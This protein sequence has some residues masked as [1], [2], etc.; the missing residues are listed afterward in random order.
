MKA[1]RY[2]G[3][4]D[5]RVE[6]V[7][8]PKIE[9]PTDVILKV[10]ST[11]ICGSD[12][13]MYEGRTDVEEGKIFGHEVM[14]IIDQAGD[15]VQLLHKGDRVVLPFN[16]ACGTCFN[17]CRGFTNACLF[18]SEEGSAG[19][20]YG[21]AGMGPYRGGQAEYVR[22]PFADFNALKLPGVPHDENEDNFLMLADIL[23]T[24]F[25]AATL[26]KVATGHSVAIYGGGPVGLLSVMSARLM[27][28]ADIYLVDPVPSRL[29]KA[30]ELGA[31]PVNPADGDPVKQIRKARRSIALKDAAR[32]GEELLLHGVLS[33]IDA[34][35][36]QAHNLQNIDEERHQQ[37]I[38]QLVNLTLPTGALG[39]I[40]VY[41]PQDPGGNDENARE[42]VYPLP[43]GQLW[44]KGLSLGTG[45]APVKRYNTHLRDAIIAGQ[46]NPGT[47]VSHHISINEAPEYYERFC[48]REDG[49]TKVVIT[50]R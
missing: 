42:G 2:R 16:I 28:A 31:I 32:P 19:A 13:H 29:D 1:V 49:V 39:V 9:A 12:L 15:A 10:T 35:G 48:R 24:A 4:K 36:Y 43:F 7:E 21:Y 34:V 22:V 26:A 38:E 5:M 3:A 18:M 20:A 44:H 27:G 41:V 50:F 30:K 14:G 8:N 11:A 37:V 25:H 46:A 17:C 40:G 23:P 45:Q 33:G 6:E 47:I